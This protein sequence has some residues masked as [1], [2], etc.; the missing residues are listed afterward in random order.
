MSGPRRKPI[1]L[2]RIPGT[3][4]SVSALTISVDPPAVAPPSADARTVALLRRARDFGV[5]SYDVAGSRFPERAERLVATAF[6]TADAELGVIVGRSLDS[7]GSERRSTDGSRPPENLVAALEA[8]LEQSRRRLAPVDISVL[9]WDPGTDTTTSGSS[10]TLPSPPPDVGTS[11]LQR[12]VPIRW[13]TTALPR[14]RAPSALYSAELSLL[15]HEVD[16]LFEPVSAEGRVGLI[17]RNPFSDGRLDG[18]RFAATARPTGPG[19]GPIDVRH[20]H[21]EFDPVLR[22]GFLTDGR[23]R[24]LAQAALHYV[25][26]RPWVVTAVVPLPNPE[27]FEEIFGFGSSP[28]L[29]PEELGRLY[30]LK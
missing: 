30:D 23:R 28:P 24:T 17:A 26:V 29:D 10:D 25:L 16:A 20:L 3:A 22:L 2:R 6:P 15:H 4:R 7:L 1:G 19:A 8:S 14:V 9:E 27:R 13:P 12:A 21:Q 18:S 11:G 5:T